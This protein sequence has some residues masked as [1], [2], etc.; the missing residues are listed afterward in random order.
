MRFPF[1]KYISST[2]LLAFGHQSKSQQLE[3][4]QIES[5][6]AITRLLNFNSAFVKSRNVEIYLPES[7][8][9]DSTKTYP[10]LYWQ[11]GQNLFDP[12][13][14]YN[15]H[16]LEMHMAMQKNNQE[17][18]V[19]GIWNTDLRYREYMPNKIYNKLNKRQQKLLR[20]EYKGSALGDNYASF[21]VKELK[22]YIDSQFR[23]SKDKA[24]TWIGGASM[25]GLIS[26]Y[27]AFE[28]PEVFGKVL[29]ISTHWPLSV[30]NNHPEFL[31]AYNKY[32]SAFENKKLNIDFYFDH[33]T[34][35][36]DA[37]YSHFQKSLDQQIKQIGNKHYTSLVFDGASHDE[38]DWGKRLSIVLAF[39][40]N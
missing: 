20:K 4:Q 30:R 9:L 25:G 10:V 13:V 24:F 7:Y 11:D 2:I 38:L 14:S 39:L 21:I 8:S 23:T 34:K 27:S 32:M 6:T 22:P 18:I 3:V 19:V 33:G 15:K 28:Y 37:W 1:W 26:W 16:P 17:F 36:I 29:A 12:K 5:P 31:E 35:N 40:S